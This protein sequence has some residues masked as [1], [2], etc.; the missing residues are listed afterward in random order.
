MKWPSGETA[1]KGPLGCERRARNRESRQAHRKI[2]EAH[3]ALTA[4]DAAAAEAV[5]AISGM[6]LAELFIVSNVARDRGKKAPEARSWRGNE[7]PRPHR[8][9]HRGHR[10]EMPALLDAL[11]APRSDRRMTYLAARVY[12]HVCGDF[13][14]VGAGG[15]GVAVFSADA[16]GLAHR[17]N[18]CGNADGRHAQRHI[19]TANFLA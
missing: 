17:A 13:A 1:F 15:V 16:G 11:H 12:E 2:L 19:A 7:L 8:H 4:V 9:R 14:G 10:Q 6:N 5:K 18:S 3:V